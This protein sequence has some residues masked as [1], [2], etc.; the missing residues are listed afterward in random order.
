M[1]V[2]GAEGT[3]EA[4][5]KLIFYNLPFFYFFCTTFLLNKTHP[6]SLAS[7]VCRWRLRPCGAPV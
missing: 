6:W 2:G 7:G 5:G 1:D 3:E 4:V